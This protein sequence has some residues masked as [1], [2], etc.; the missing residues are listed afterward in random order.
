[1]PKWTHI[2][3]HHTESAPTATVE[4]ITAWHKAR[5][6]ATIGYHYLLKRDAKGTPHLLAAR[7]DKQSGAHAGGPKQTK[8]GRPWNSFALGLSVV[9]SFHPGH[10]FS[11]HLAPGTA[12]Y[13]GLVEALAHL[14]IKYGID[15]ANI[16]YHRDVKS[17]D[18]PGD[19]FV[20]RATLRRDVHTAIVR[21]KGGSA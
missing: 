15:S 1:M 19:W 4:Q 10:A 20:D 9:G 18:C 7:S 13:G 2:L 12:L 17:T 16:F 6:F 21:V 8:D 5:G 11:E 14:C 3:V